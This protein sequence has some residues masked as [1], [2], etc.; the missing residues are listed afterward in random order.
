MSLNGN[1]FYIPTSPLPILYWSTFKFVRVFRKIDSELGIHRQESISTPIQWCMK[2]FSDRRDANLKRVFQ[3]I[4]WQTVFQKLSENEQNWTK[5]GA[6][7]Q[8][9]PL[10]PPMPVCHDMLLPHNWI[11]ITTFLWYLPFLVLVYLP[12]PS[13]VCRRCVRNTCRPWLPRP[14]ETMETNECNINFRLI[15]M[16]LV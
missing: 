3:S 11:F 5:S 2:N 16:Y 7:P 15:N 12:G 6:R 10:D 9:L 1:F 13:T 4:I 14:P 8:H